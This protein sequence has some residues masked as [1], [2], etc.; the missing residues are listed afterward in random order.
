MFNEENTLLRK[1]DIGLF[2]SLYHMQFIH[3]IHGY[4]AAS[5]NLE[6]PQKLI[7]ALQDKRHMHTHTH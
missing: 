1:D 2:S 4:K 3:Y 5:K 6:Y 7:R